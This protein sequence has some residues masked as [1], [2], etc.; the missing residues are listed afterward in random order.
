[1]S[2]IFGRVRSA[3]RI[4]LVR[5]LGAAKVKSRLFWEL[6]SRPTTLQ[7]IG[8]SIRKSGENLILAAFGAGLFLSEAPWQILL[9]VISGGII[10]VLSGSMMESA[11]DTSGGDS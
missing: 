10:L 5:L 4:G 8:G 7:R 1:M 3:I 9:V 2:D 11:N 6:T